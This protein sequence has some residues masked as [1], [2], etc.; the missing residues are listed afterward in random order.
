M[1]K[2]S[3][4][5]TISSEEL[6]LTK[7]NWF[8][9]VTKLLRGGIYL[10]AGE[11]GSG[12]TTLS[13]QL[14]LDIAQSG[15]KVLYL[16]TEQSPSDLKLVILRLL[17]GNLSEEIDNNMYIEVLTNLEDLKLWR[18]HLFEEYSPGPY[19]G[20]QLIVIDS[21]QGGGVIPTARKTYEELVKFTRIAKNK[22]VTSLLLSHVTKTGAIAGPKDI[23]HHV[24]CIIQ[25]K[26]AF[27]FRPLFVP[28]NR[29]G[30]A[31]L[32]PFILEMDELGLK[33][34]PH[35][36][37]K[38]STVKAVSF[39]SKTIAEVQAKVQ[40]PKWGE[41]PGI[42]A[43]YLPS[44]KLQH[45]IN[46]ICQL[47][48]V[49]ASDLV[50]QINCYIPR[51]NKNRYEFD[52]DLAIAVSVLSSYLQHEVPQDYGFCGEVDLEG[53]IRAESMKT[54]FDTILNDKLVKK[55]YIDEEQLI[56]E[57]ILSSNNKEFLEK[58]K[59]MKKLFVPEEVKEDV[60]SLLKALGL[61]LEVI[62]VT[63]LQDL[64]PILWPDLT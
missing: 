31:K 7:M 14:A 9:E 43:P 17:E 58:L 57:I 59:N 55:G 44:R 18:S 42:R 8:R 52:F 56:S 61:N 34:S 25:Y 49:D 10:L 24:D 63:F 6:P 48:D 1:P 3:E 37:S 54:K 38:V 19:R 45:I 32:D 22:G 21:I 4:I 15:M 5:P 62:G 51:I 28:K 35:V 60:V 13:L 50:Y 29:F 30:P 23:E 26:R 20:V 27:K 2:P 47:P 16:T 12:K 64:L 33:P 11:P 53:G 46:A 40:V 36:T 41:R 39:I